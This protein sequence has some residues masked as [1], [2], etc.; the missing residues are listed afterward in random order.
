MIACTESPTVDRYDVTRVTVDILPDVALLEI[1]DV[2]THEEVDEDKEGIEAWQTL[3]HVC[4]KWRNVVFG[5]PRRLNLRLYC[6]SGTPVRETLDVWPLLPIVIGVYP[7][8][9]WDNDNIIA[10]LEH[11][12]R[13]CKLV[14]I[15]IPNSKTEKALAALQQPFPALTFLQLMFW[16]DTG[17]VLPASF[18]GGSAPALQS[19]WLDRIP[20]PGLPKLLLTATNLNTLNIQ[21]IPHSGYISPE[22][23]A[24]A[25]SVLTRLKSLSI[26]FESPRSRPDRRPRRLPPP[27]HTVLPVLTNLMFKGVAEYLE[28]LVARIDA[29]LLDKLAIIFLHQMIFNCPH[30]TRFISRTPKFKAHDEARVDFSHH[31]VMVIFPPAFDGAFELELGISCKQ[32]EWQLSSVAQVCITSFPRALISAVEHLYIESVSLKLHWQDDIENGQWLEFLT[33]FTAVKDLYISLELMPNITRALKEL[34]GVVLPTL[35]TLFLEEPIPS[36]PVQEAIEQFVAAR[37]LAGHSLIISRWD[38]EAD[39]GSEP[40]DESDDD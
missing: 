24:T 17:P 31:E 5:S 22:A 20:F 36:G 11:N 6:S 15:D 8:D 29:P 2:Y 38:R 7:V 39:E 13:I 12:D 35:Q 37:Q 18:L 1:F 10:A 19:I 27:T 4:R 14:I 40:S 3:V 23:M 33:P 30:L 25:L 21:H 9:K 28:D 32:S 34:A 16:N 26:E